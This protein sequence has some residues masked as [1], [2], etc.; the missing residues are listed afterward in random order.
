MLTFL[1]PRPGRAR[2]IETL[3]WLNLI[4]MLSITFVNDSRFTEDRWLQW[5]F[6]KWQVTTMTLLRYGR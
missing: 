3:L 2:V 6:C 1:R 4:H 5:Q